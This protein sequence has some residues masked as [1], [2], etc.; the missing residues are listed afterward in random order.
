[1]NN[2]DGNA[3]LTFKIL[4]QFLLHILL[5]GFR[6]MVLFLVVAGSWALLNATQVSF[7]QNIAPFVAIALGFV[8][9]RVLFNKPKPP[10]V[11]AI[12]PETSTP[13]V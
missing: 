11:S 2:I 6:R 13:N 7:L 3:P 12:K 10:V 1:M 9:Y 5:I 4:G 8:A